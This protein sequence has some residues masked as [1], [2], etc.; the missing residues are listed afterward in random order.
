M[1]HFSAI[2]G[3]RASLVALIAAASIMVSSNA[4]AADVGSYKDYDGAYVEEDWSVGAL[5]VGGLI[6]FKPTYEGSNDYEAFGFPYIFPIFNGGPGFFSHID[7]R[8]LDDVRY[9]LIERDGFIA[10]PLV[11]YDLGRDEGDGDLLAG[12]GD[13]DG[14]LIG[15]G[16]AGYQFGPV[17]FDVSYHHYFG[18]ADGYQIRLG[19]EY[20]HDISERTKMT[21]RVGA[22]YADGAYMDAYFSVSSAATVAAAFD[23]DAG[24]K[25]VYAQIGV[26]TELDERWSLCGNIRY[27]HLL[28]D[29]AD[30]TIVESENQFYGFLALSYKLDLAD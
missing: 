30:S 11:G 12:L 20:V 17:L 26:E 27:S 14:G 2:A 4:L 16:F 5:K 29:A 10:G 7:A 9:K 22:N 18:D 21:T 6:G 15:G 1:S 25:D 23:A 13:V 19:A 3:W 8:A 28:G 24:F